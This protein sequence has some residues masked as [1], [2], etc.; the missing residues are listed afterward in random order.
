MRGSIFG[1]LVGFLV[2]VQIENSEAKSMR[3]RTT[4]VSSAVG[5]G[6]AVS[7]GWIVVSVQRKFEGRYGFHTKVLCYYTG[8]GFDGP[9]MIWTPGTVRSGDRCVDLLHGPDGGGWKRAPFSRYGE[10]TTW[11]TMALP[12]SRE[13]A[14]L[15]CAALYSVLDC[16]THVEQVSPTELTR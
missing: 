16:E 7:P 6:T 1:H 12:W 13:L 14:E 5:A 15:Q 2:E 4:R 9:V 10:A 8:Q 11:H 3:S